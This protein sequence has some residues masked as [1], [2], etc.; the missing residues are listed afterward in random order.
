MLGALIAWGFV[1]GELIG[2]TFSQ[3]GGQTIGFRAM[4]RECRVLG[5]SL[6]MRGFC[7]CERRAQK[8]ELFP[9]PQ[10]RINNRTPLSHCMDVFIMLLC[11]WLVAR[12]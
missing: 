1:P 10:N 6:S 8:S 2:H 11:Y 12:P 3:G 7:V 4:G 9:P 5:P